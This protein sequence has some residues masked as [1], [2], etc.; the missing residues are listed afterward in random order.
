[1][2]ED[3]PKLFS[4]I[5][6]DG[7]QREL[8]WTAIETYAGTYTRAR[9]E[10]LARLAF[11]TKPP[12][13]GLQQD[14]LATALTAFHKAF[15]DADPTFQPAERQDQILAAAALLQYF[16]TTS[17]AAMAVTNTACA[18]AR[19]AALPIDLASVAENEMSRLAAARRKRRNLG[20][21]E[22]EASDFSFEPDFAEAQPNSPTTFKGVF[23]QFTA[24]VDEALAD[25]AAKFNESTKL[26]VDAGKKADEELDMLSW[27]FGQRALLPD[28]PF[29]E[30]PAD[31]KPLVFARDLASL[32]TIYPGPNSVPALMARAGIKST[33]KIK[34]ADAVNAIPDGWT[35][36]ALKDRKPSPATSPVHFALLKRQET[37]AGD[38][39][40]A[41]W[42]AITGLDV[43]AAMSPIELA[44]LFYRE[45]LWLR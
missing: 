22:I 15:T 11:G 32:T 29:T 36:E 41:G 45:I 13:G 5:S 12:A 28:Q 40:H 34:I 17:I 9:I 26:L 16:G 35:T 21:V 25:L 10:M 31:Q 19:K 18:G 38:G 39:W 4:E 33:G 24:A 23:D 3:F 43:A 2:H 6:T 27:V 1:M 30:V 20:N 14:D 8:R 44:E 7:A 37:G 42:A